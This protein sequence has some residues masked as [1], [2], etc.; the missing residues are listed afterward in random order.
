MCERDIHWMDAVRREDID[1]SSERCGHRGHEH[2]EAPVLQFLNN[3]RGNEGL[4][5]LGQRR[6]PH[7]FLIP[8]RHSLSQTPKECVA[9]YSFEKRLLDALLNRVASGRADGSADE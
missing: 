1:S 4:L 7:I 2:R 8:P 6:L 9:W 3:E 5:D